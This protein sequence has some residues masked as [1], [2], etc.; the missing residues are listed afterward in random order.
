MSNNFNEFIQEVE[1][2]L[3]QEKFDK[4]WNQYGKAVVGGFVVII[5]LS[6]AFNI[7]KSHQTKQRDIISQQFS[8]AQ[9]L[10]FGKKIGDGLSAMEGIATSSH[11]NY[12]VLAKLNIAATLRQETGHKDFDRAEAIYKELMAS[13]ST[14]HIFRQLA[15]VLYIG[16]RLERITNEKDELEPLSK[17]LEPLI[18]DTAPYR[19]LALELKGV[20]ELRQNDHAKAA[21]TFLKIAQDD[22]A[23]KDLRSRAQVVTQHLA[24]QLARQNQKAE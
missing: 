8:N 11:R 7:W 3:R 20:I 9:N 17:Q 22:K 24:A 23:P 6:A 16:L 4:L 15:T 19:H 1:S 10:I 2:D 5:G 12:A 14:D 13:S 21:E 18:K